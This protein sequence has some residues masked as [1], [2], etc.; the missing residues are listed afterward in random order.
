MKSLYYY[1]GMAAAV[2]MV[3]AM[4]LLSGCGVDP[5]KGRQALEAQGLTDVEIGGWAWLGC[6][7]KDAFRS[8]FTAT[9]AN[10]KPVSGVLCS[11]YFKGVTIR[12]Y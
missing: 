2:L 12:Y 10:G 4:V 11:A 3:V 8:K 9:G 7:E 1:S 5:V 6:D